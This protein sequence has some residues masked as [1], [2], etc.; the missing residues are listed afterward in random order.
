[1]QQ[2]RAQRRRILSLAFSSIA[3]GCCALLRPIS[4]L[5]ID[6]NKKGFEARSLADVFKNLNGGSPT[7]SKNIQ[8]KVPEIADDDADVP[9]YVASKI[10]NTQMIAIIV[11]ENVHPLAA[12]FV[13]SNGAE[14]TVYIRVKVR[15]TSPINALVQADGKYLLVSKEVKVT[16]ADC[17]D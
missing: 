12:S 8:L 7:P 9:I 5:A 10:P 3:A 17:A 1:M 16:T 6:W 11:S 15:R 14:P 13:F 2:Q 4:A